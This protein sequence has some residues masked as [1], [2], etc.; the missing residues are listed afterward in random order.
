MAVKRKVAKFGNN[1]EHDT[2]L[3]YTR[4]LWGCIN[5]DTFL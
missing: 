5:P 1:H 4:V 2:N 3:I